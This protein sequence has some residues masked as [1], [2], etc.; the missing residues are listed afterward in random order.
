MLLTVPLFEVTLEAEIT[1]PSAEVTLGFEL[2]VLLVAETL[3]FALKEPLDSETVLFSWRVELLSRV[4]A[5]LLSLESL[6]VTLEVETRAL[7]LSEVDWV[8]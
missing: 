6:R 7:L 4:F 1:D 2:T 5:V 3:L 8:W